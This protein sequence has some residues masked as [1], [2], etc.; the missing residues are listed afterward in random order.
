ML[1]FYR[2]LLGKD[3][4]GLSM[5]ELQQLENELNVSLLSVKAK[6][7]FIL[8]LIFLAILY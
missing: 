7:F 6:V 3:L 5:K 2:R 1:L 8:C 4:S